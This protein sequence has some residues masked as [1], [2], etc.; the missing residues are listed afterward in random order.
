[1]ISSKA[2]AL[3]A[4]LVGVFTSG[5]LAQETT[6]PL[7][8]QRVEGRIYEG[9]EGAGVVEWLIEVDRPRRL[10]HVERVTTFPGGTRM[11]VDG[12]RHS[13]P[14]PPG[15]LQRLT[16]AL[17][18]AEAHTWPPLAR[19]ARGPEVKELQRRLISHG[20]RGLS[21]DGIFGRH[22]EQE[23]R[24]FQ[25][26]RR[27]RPSGVYDGATRRRLEPVSLQ[28][29]G[30]ETIDPRALG[31]L[32]VIARSAQH[33]QEP[34]P[35]EL[36]GEFGRRGGKT[37][38]QTTEGRYEVEGLH[39]GL[40]RATGVLGGA[41]AKAL[42][43]PRAG[44]P[45]LAVLTSLEVAVTGRSLPEGLEPTDQTARVVGVFD[46]PRGGGRSQTL[47]KVRTSEGEVGL[48]GRGREAYGPAGTL[49]ER[50]SSWVRDWS[51][52]QPPATPTRPPLPATPRQGLAD[53]V[54]GE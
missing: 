14:L 40:Q 53:R 54:R 5:A 1:M 33:G 16:N 45:D 4:L 38:L 10:A 49:A 24:R 36:E 2:F 8:W 22:T 7:S 27:L 31:V 32:R 51:Q 23:L 18:S 19:G 9:H 13:Y 15:L 20:A 48:L 39:A 52:G 11:R 43:W 30:V 29:D 12:S 46:R 37:Y 42:V 17:A 25:Y 21:A 26:H 44:Q 3:S 41:K 47:L 50:R 28:A 34:E 35:R 6:L